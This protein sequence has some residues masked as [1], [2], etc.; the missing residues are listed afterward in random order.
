MSPISMSEADNLAVAEKQT[1]QRSKLSDAVVITELQEAAPGLEWY[2][3]TELGEMMNILGKSAQERLTQYIQGHTRQVT[4]EDG[5]IKFVEFPVLL[6]RRVR[7]EEGGNE[8][9]FAFI[10][11]DAGQTNKH[12]VDEAWSA[13]ISILANCKTSKPAT[14]KQIQALDVGDDPEEEG[15]DESTDDNVSYVQAN[16]FVIGASDVDTPLRDVS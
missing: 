2:S 15:E 4:F 11:K 8:Y 13:A 12:I 9:Y 1:V 3:Q 7:R 5:Q 6:A 14:Q 10:N 16:A